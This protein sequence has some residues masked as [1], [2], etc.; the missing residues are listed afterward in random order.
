[1]LA[2][3]APVDELLSAGYMAVQM[4]IHNDSP[5]EVTNVAG[6]VTITAEVVKEN[7]TPSRVT[8]SPARAR[9][10]IIDERLLH[11]KQG[12]L[13]ASW[14]I[15]APKQGESFTISYQ[16]VSLQTEWQNGLFEIANTG[17]SPFVRRRPYPYE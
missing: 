12:G 10:Y 3:H 13:W 8:K 7:R 17:G 5:A 15:V 6:T 1:M 9:E 16:I 14:V 4:F 11:K 2:G